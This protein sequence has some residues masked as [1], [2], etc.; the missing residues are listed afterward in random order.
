MNSPVVIVQ[1]FTAAG[2]HGRSTHFIAHRAVVCNTLASVLSLCALLPFLEVLIAMFLF[3]A[4]LSLL[5][6]VGLYKTLRFKDTPSLMC[7]R[8]AKP[9]P[10]KLCTGGLFIVYLV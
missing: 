3:R 1:S 10:G 8:R 9:L 7:A 5:V 4:T 2:G 6:I